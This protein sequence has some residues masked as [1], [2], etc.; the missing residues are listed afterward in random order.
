VY[1]A[2]TL[3]VVAGLGSFLLP[4]Y[5][6]MARAS[7]HDRPVT[8]AL[9]SADRV[10]LG[11]A[12]T[13]AVISLVA[14]LLQPVVEPLLTGGD[15]PMPVLAVAGWGAYAVAGAIL[16]PYS[17]VA[18]V[19]RRQRRVLGFRLLEFVALGAVALLVFTVD[20]GEA[21]APLA[22]AVGPLLAA[23]AV[24]QAVLRPLVR[25]EHGAPRAPVGV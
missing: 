5:V 1:T 3:T 16:L 11:L 7:A 4:H 12:G 19:Q 24:R 17:G 22:L 2:P 13:V 10:A 20:G 14:V 23:V 25:Q 6:A 9:R 21:W 15:Y 18:T 8:R